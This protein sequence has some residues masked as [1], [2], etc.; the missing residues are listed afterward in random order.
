MGYDL[1]MV[2]PRRAV[3]A[4]LAL[5]CAASCDGAADRPKNVLLISIDSTRRGRTIGRS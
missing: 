5:A 1:P 4:A 2:R 3:L